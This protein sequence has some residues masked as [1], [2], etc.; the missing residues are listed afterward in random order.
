MVVI[1]PEFK[2]TST[3][4]IRNFETDVPNNAHIVQDLGTKVFFDR[5][6]LNGS[7]GFVSVKVC[8]GLG[9]SESC[10]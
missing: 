9:V 4:F 1:L 10:Y 6:S 2:D 3:L 8:P 5:I 7:N